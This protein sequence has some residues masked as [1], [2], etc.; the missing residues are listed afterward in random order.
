V[1]RTTS[2]PGVR[3]ATAISGLLDWI[4]ASAALLPSNSTLACPPL[5]MRTLE[6]LIARGGRA[7]AFRRF[8]TQT[9]ARS[10]WDRPAAAASCGETKNSGLSPTNTR[11]VFPSRRTEMEELEFSG[12]RELATPRAR[13]AMASGFP[14]RSVMTSISFTNT[15]PPF[16]R[17]EAAWAELT[18]STVKA[19]ISP[20]IL[21]FAFMLSVEGYPSWGPDHPRKLRKRHHITTTCN[22]TLVSSAAETLFLPACRRVFR[23]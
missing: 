11:T 20:R 3:P 6:V 10:P 18:R 12:A 2:T 7:S 8:C 22:G 13:V 4:R 1:D 9:S 23:V 16:V 21:F 17:T 5:G 19:K 14:D 15:C